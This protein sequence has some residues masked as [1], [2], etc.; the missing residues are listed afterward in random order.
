MANVLADYILDN[1]LGKFN[2]EAT[3]IYLCS[4]DPT[5]YTEATSTYA[6]GNKNLGAGTCFGAPAA[7][8]PNGRKVSSGAITNGSV[9]GTGTAAKWG[10]VDSVN[11]RLLANGALAASQAVTSGNTFSL[12]SYDIGVPGQ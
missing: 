6:L 11:T 3:H 7:R 9:T 2:A 10:A 8:S 5:T 1:G 4:A 12:P